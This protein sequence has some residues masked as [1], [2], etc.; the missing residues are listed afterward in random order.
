M[1]TN[2]GNGLDSVVIDMD[3]VPRG[4]LTYLQPP[5]VSLLGGANATV[6]IRVIV[7]AAF[8]DVLATECSMTVVASSQRSDAEATLDIIV[9]YEQFH[10]IEL[11]LRGVELTDPVRPVA[12]EGL[13]S[14]WPVIDLGNSSQVVVTLGV[15]NMGN[16]PDTVLVGIFAEDD[17]IAFD[18]TS[19][20]FGMLAGE[21]SDF[22]W[23]VSVPDGMPGGLYRIWVHANSEDSSQETR[24]VP[25]DL[26]VVPL[27]DEEDFGDLAYFDPSGDE[28]TF[29]FEAG[30]PTGTVRTSKGGTG[31]VSAV[32]IVSLDVSV[33][34]GTAEVVVTLVFSGDVVDDGTAEYWLYFVNATH[35]Q[36]GAILD[37]EDYQGGGFQWDFSDEANV[38]LPLFLDGDVVRVGGTGES[39][40]TLVSGKG[41]VVTL[42]GKRLRE[43]GL[44][45]GSGFGMYAYAHVL[46]TSTE[47]GW[48]MT[49]TWDS[50]GVGAAPAPEE[51][52]NKLKEGSPLGAALAPLA[53][54]VALLAVV[55]L[56]R[57][58]G[59]G[60]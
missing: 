7:P 20:S 45:P 56:G 3:R 10:R 16:G 12:P 38:L 30:E 51:F 5:E 55:V 47:D 26:E 27:F 40:D 57:R 13:F 22:Y 33:D 19:A 23:V 34:T 17:R 6:T 35:R 29:H 41:V 18:G 59:V 50:A 46:E 28:Y 52:D 37:P 2:T 49:V 21:E 11:T 32:D 42:P 24:S 36:G 53:M 43:L 31:G 14:P 25:I 15:K 39:L 4:W 58:G 9:G 48:S 60:R 44:E 8:E 54:A 1:V